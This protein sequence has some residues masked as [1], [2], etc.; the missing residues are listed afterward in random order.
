[1]SKNFDLEIKKI[2]GSTVCDISNDLEEITI[3]FSSKAAIQSS[4]W[5]ILPSEGQR[6]SS[7]DHMQN[8]GSVEPIDAVASLKSKIKDLKVINGE[9]P[10]L[11]GDIRLTFE[12]GTILE[13]FNFTANEVW[14]VEFEDGTGQYSNYV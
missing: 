4:F 13:I 12:N 2:V 11:T 7:F 6:F 1:V 14:E 10:K 9:C 3:R 5:R 8:Y